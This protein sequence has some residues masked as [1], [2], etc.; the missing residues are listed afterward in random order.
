MADPVATSSSLVDADAALAAALTLLGRLTPDQREVVALR[1]IVGLTVGE[2]AT[3]VH[4]SDGAVRCCCHRGLRTLAQQL[5]A[6][7]MARGVTI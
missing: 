1:V 4:K 6:D 2:T 7:Q 5:D 3:I